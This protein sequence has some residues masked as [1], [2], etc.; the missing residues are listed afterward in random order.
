MKISS[1]DR[2]MLR[3]APKW[4]LDRMRARKAAEV[5]ARHYEA[6]APGRRTSGWA[7]THGDANAV[8]AVAISELRMHARDLVR[9]NGWAKKG[10]RVVANHT[11][12]WGIVPKAKGTAAARA[13]ELWADWANT[14]QCDADG[15]LNFSGIQ[16]L[17]MRSLVDAGEILIRRRWRRPEDKL[18]IPLQLQVL[19]ADFIDTSRDAPSSQSGG[20]IQLGVEFDKLGRRAAYW[21]YDQHPGGRL[22]TSSSRRVP[23]SE[24]LH[25]F[26]ADRPGQTRG[27]SWLGAGIVNLKDLDEYE[28]ATLV[29]QKI[30]A[31]FA[32][33]VTDIDGADDPTGDDGDDGDGDEKDLID[34]VQPGLVT[35][36]PPGRTVTFG[37][38]PTVNDYDAF[39]KT[40][41]RKIA[42]VIGVGYED[43]TGDY[44]Q[45]NFSSARM[46]RLAHWADVHDWQFN[47]LI[48]QLC[49]GVWA[50]AME[51]AITAGE[52]V[53]APTAEWT[54]PPM[55]M[56]EPDKEGLAYMRL[57]RTG[58]MT[59]S[60]MV[61]E[62][63]GDPEAHWAE[64]AA[65][66]KKLDEFGIK[67]DA[68]VRAVSSA[69]LTQERLG[70]GGG[71]GP[72]EK[73][74]KKDG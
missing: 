16:H 59:F 32:A 9:N 48:P 5:F 25:V 40:Q 11:A 52:F 37:T 61:R 28:D 55:P 54:P 2:F 69:G 14:T 51:A 70:G 33:F 22:S 67:L 17:V 63:G 4:S 56:I 60:E 50:W 3:V 68:D 36:L 7:R 18:P 27:I 29:K 20:P 39:T 73:S 58:V 71:G 46:A 10:R 26:Y 13:A 41:L 35:H 1:F 38:P 43:L 64:Y 31:C 44:S 74:D 42:A 23:A 30:A 6:A 66:L 12:G 8:M 47:M 24:I 57:V 65:D 19:E 49:D 62:R 72:P 21:L 53:E 34:R 45:V 15:R